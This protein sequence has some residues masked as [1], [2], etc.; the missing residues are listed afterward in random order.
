MTGAI[1]AVGGA[2]YIGSHVV[3]ELLRLGRAVVVFDNFSNARREAL[4]RVQALT[5]RAP[6]VIE[7]D[8]LDA[9]ALDAAMASQPVEAVIHLA[10]LKSVPESVR[11]PDAYYAV[12]VGGSATLLAAMRRRGV[13]R[14]VFSSSAVVYGAI[15]SGAISESAP[16]CPLSPYGR[17]K[18]IVESLLDDMVIADPA[19]SALS[20]RYFNPVG[21]DPSG[22]IGEDPRTPPSNLFPCIAETALGRRAALEIFGSDYPTPDGTGVRDF[23]HVSDLAHGHVAALDALARGGLA[24]RHERVNLGVGTGYSVREALRAFAA[25]TGR[26]IPHRLVARRPGD[27]AFSVADPAKAR[28]LLGWTARRGLAEMCADHWNWS[29]ANP[30]GYDVTP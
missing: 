8:L 22:R 10:G 20:L 4:R 17:S 6:V 5:G 14:L 15:D 21:A 2:G 30:Q 7:G 24:G 3:L 16:T 19:F 23:I 12:N 25:A 28:T 1:L 13:R 29:R 9:S 27:I 11:R 18:L 26:D